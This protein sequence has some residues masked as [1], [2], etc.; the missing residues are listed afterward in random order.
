M[1]G[2]EPD[3]AVAVESAEEGVCRLDVAARGRYAEADGTIHPGLRHRRLE[4]RNRAIPEPGEAGDAGERLLGYRVR[5][6]VRVPVDDHPVRLL[7]RRIP[8]H[9]DNAIDSGRGTSM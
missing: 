8:Y 4:A 6:D 5:P 3:E 9:H 7:F 2:A 1:H